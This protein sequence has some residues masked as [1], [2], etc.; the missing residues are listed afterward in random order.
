[1]FNYSTI[2]LVISEKETGKSWVRGFNKP[3][4]AGLYKFKTEENHLNYDISVYVL[5]YV[6][7]DG[8]V[9][10]EPLTSK[11]QLSSLYGRS[12]NVQQ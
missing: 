3:A 10:Y 1:M 9:R 8:D 2:L 11:A 7:T 6:D 12:A 5:S 4:D